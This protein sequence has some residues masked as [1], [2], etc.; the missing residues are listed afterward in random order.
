MIKTCRLLGLCLGLVFFMT[1]VTWASCMSPRYENPFDEAQ[2]VYLAR[3]EAVIPTTVGQ[4]KNSTAAQIKVVKIY[5]AKDIE[6]VKQ[7]NKLSAF[8]KYSPILFTIGE[9]YLLYNEP[10]ISPCRAFD[11]KKINPDVVRLFERQ[12]S[13]VWVISE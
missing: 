10:A 9:Q 5:K 4:L 7:I 6:Q 3:V 13:P 12:Y 11:N 2:D 8:D 1:G